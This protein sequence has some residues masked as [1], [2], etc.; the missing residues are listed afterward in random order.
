MPIKR[1]EDQIVSRGVLGNMSRWGKLRKGG[2]SG[3]KSIGR[4]LSYFRLQL[5]PEYEELVRPAFEAMYG[6]EPTILHN[7]MIA[8]ED[9]DTALD[10]WYESWA[11]AKL[12]KRCDGETIAAHWDDSLG[13]VISTHPG[14]SCNPLDRDCSIVGRLDI[15]LPDLCEELG[16][17]GKLTVLTG[18]E[19]DVRALRASMFSAGYALKQ[20]PTVSFWHVPF[21][22]GRS[23]KEVPVTINGKRSLKTMSLLYADIEPAFN[24]R[25]VAPALTSTTQKL[26]AGANPATG[27][28]PEVIIESARAWDWDYVA[29]ETLGL[30]DNESHQTAAIN[31]MVA[32]GELHDD[33][34]DT[35][36]ITTISLN[37]EQRNAEKEAEAQAKADKPKSRKNGAKSNEKAEKPSAAP[38]KV[39]NDLDWNKDPKR[40]LALIAKANE[41]FKLNHGQ[42]VSALSWATDTQLESVEQ[43]A[44][45]ATDAWAACIIHA[46]GYNRDRV[47]TYFGDTETPLRTA[48]NKI[49]EAIQDIPF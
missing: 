27:E 9:A 16:V 36:A 17:W 19:Y 14:C 28:M 31:K 2:E 13:R 40:V 45:T 18:S 15:V 41:T 49:L 44:G 22:I 21:V 7:V 1:I 34:D 8:S 25:V 5:E 38:T 4:D 12:L 10:Y 35:D 30:F 33:M 32:S 42:V 6:K 47:M 39:D 24:R 11:H 48:A 3:E 43:F 23:P 29:A 46:H 37:R 20:F 26:L